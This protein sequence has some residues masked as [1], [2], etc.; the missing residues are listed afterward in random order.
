MNWLN[1]SKAQSRVVIRTKGKTY[2][3][4]FQNGKGPRGAGGPGVLMDAFL[5]NGMG[6]ET[7]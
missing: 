2:G 1:R 5:Q 4:G 6:R 3:Q 7:G